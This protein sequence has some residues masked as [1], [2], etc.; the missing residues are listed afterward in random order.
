MRRSG[1]TPWPAAAAFSPKN[2]TNCVLGEIFFFPGQLMKK[3]NNS[4][5]NGTGGNS[6]A[7]MRVHFSLN[8]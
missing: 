6:S 4:G 7:T 5:K 3:E 8:L 1:W 2:G